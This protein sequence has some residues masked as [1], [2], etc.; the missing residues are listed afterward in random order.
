ML[1]WNRYDAVSVTFRLSKVAQKILT[2]RSDAIVVNSQ[3]LSRGGGKAEP[4]L[5]GRV[6]CSCVA[7]KADYLA[8][9]MPNVRLSPDGDQQ[10]ST[11]VKIFA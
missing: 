11:M 6:E 8:M 10:F 5:Q 9:Q 2:S 4:E 3:E 7:C 1:Q